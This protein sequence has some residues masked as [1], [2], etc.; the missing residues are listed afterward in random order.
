MP[1]VFFKSRNTLEGTFV[2]LLSSIL[3]FF[4]EFIQ[5]HSNHVASGASKQCS[6][7]HWCLWEPALAQQRPHSDPSDWCRVGTCFKLAI[8][9]SPSRFCQ[10]LKERHCIFRIILLG[11]YKQGTEQSNLPH[12]Q[13]DLKQTHRKKR[14]EDQTGVWIPV[15]PKPRSSLIFPGYKK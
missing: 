9:I 1:F 3:T 11:I 2:F 14:G 8:S 4:R 13:R 10:R 12:R 6:Q 15:V 7:T 5:P